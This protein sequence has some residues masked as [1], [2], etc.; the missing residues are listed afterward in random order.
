MARHLVIVESPAKARTLGRVLGQDFLV[1]ASMGHVRDLP[2]DRLAVDTARGFAVEYEVLPSR[3]RVLTELRAAAREAETI[4]LAADPDREGEAICWHLA[5]E[6][7]PAAARKRFRRVAFHEITQRAV[8]EAF[9]A[10]RDVDARKVDAQQARRILDRLVGYGLS[11]LLWQKLQPGLSAGRVQ[12]VALR[13][14]CERERESEAFSPRE[15]WTIRARLDAGAPPVFAATLVKAGGVEARVTTALEADS[16]RRALEAA[17]YRVG[18]LVARERH[19]APAPPFVTSTLQQEAFRRLRF[20]VKKTMQVAQRLYEGVELGNEG[21][22]GL[23]TYMRTDSTHIAPEAVAAAREHV[24]RRFG[25]AYAPETPNVFRAPKSAQEA[26]EAIR[27]TDLART[28]DSLAG[29]LAKDELALYRLVYDRFVASQMAAAV[30]DELLVDVEARPLA[31]PDAPAS[32]LLRAKG[33]TLRFPGFLAAYEETPDEPPREAGIAREPEAGALPPLR[34]DQ[35]LALVKVE[36]ERRLTEPPPRFTE[37]SLVKELERCGIGRPSTYAAILATLDARDY[38]TKQKGRLAPTALGFSVVDLLVERFPELISTRYTAAMEDDLDAIEDGRQTLLGALTAFWRGFE[39]ALA[40]G[41]ARAAS[42]PRRGGP[43]GVHGERAGPLPRLRRPSRRAHRPLRRVPGLQPLPGVSPHREEAGEDGGRH[44]PAL[45][46][47]RRRRARGRGAASSTAAAATQPAASRPTTGRSPRAAPSAAAPTC[48]RSRRSATAASSSAAT[49][50]VTSTG[51]SDDAVLERRVRSRGRIVATRD[52]VR[53]HG[54]AHAAPSS[55]GH[56]GRVPVL[57]HGRARLRGRVVPVPHALHRRHGPCPHDRARDL[58]GRPGLRKRPVRTRRRSPRHEHAALVCASRGRGRPVLSPVSHAA[59]S[60]QHRVPRARSLD[61]SDLAPQPWAEGLVRRGLPF[62]ALH[63]HGRHPA[64]AH[65]VRDSV[66]SGSGCAAR[67][68][69]LL[70]HGGRR[71]RMPAGRLLPDRGLGSGARH[72]GDVARQPHHRRRLSTCSAARLVR[73][74]RPPARRSSSPAP[75]GIEYTFLQSRVAFSCIAV[76]GGLTMLYEIAWFRL[77]V[78]SIGGTVHSFSTMLAGFVAGIAAG[79]GVAAWLSRSPR[80]ALALFGVCELLIGL[81]TL[82]PFAL[83]E[84]LPFACFQ[85]GSR[86]VHSPDNYGLYTSLVVVFAM[87]LM[88]VPAL[89]MGAALPLASRVR[90]SRLDMLGRGVGNVFSVNTVGNVV[91]AV[92]VG[93]VVLPAL[94]LER[95]FLLGGVSS[96][97]LGVVILWAWRRQGPDRWWRS[98]REALTAPAAAAGPRLWP[99]ALLLVLPHGALAGAGLALLGPQGASGGP[100][101]LGAQGAARL[102][103]RAPAGPRAGRGPL[104][105]RRGGRLGPGRAVPSARRRSGAHRAR[106]RKA[107]RR[108]RPRHVD[109]DL[110]GPPARVPPPGA[111]VGDGRR[112]GQRRHRGRRPAP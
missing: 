80:N 7:R 18:A 57:R 26:H 15:H 34:L 33:S 36:T 37:A 86:L 25:P 46:R 29:V 78:L 23:V 70:Q 44:L 22:V 6:L 43:R 76:A 16:L 106:E 17:A 32:H 98:L 62:R 87:L 107:R 39:A 71:V 74:P 5:E 38:V 109:P 90:V 24:L 73:R 66:R 77:L 54:H 104:Q 101:P 13:I 53:V 20:G 50:A 19:R 105:P 64:A 83:F 99:G 14:V 28:P 112:T 97:T 12:S 45:Q 68:P 95:T 10:P 94:G 31:A 2:K 100:V 84:R 30:Y 69:V 85:I 56:P 89:L 49:S 111:P 79:A 110:P 108:V 1:R 93:L 60:F 27:P 61:R 51:R 35:A 47:G 72:G 42:V 8:E 75:G 65:E 59:G 40:G 11:P 41:A 3:R 82:V 58:H 92:L 52:S 67:P 55:R 48:S 81:C 102:V 21:P 103:C 88:G 63:P 9:R 96:G 4:T 91:G